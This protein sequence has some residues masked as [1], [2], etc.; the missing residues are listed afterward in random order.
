MIFYVKGDIIIGNP[1]KG[2][3][4]LYYYDVSYEGTKVFSNNLFRGSELIKLSDSIRSDSDVK[5]IE[6]A[7]R[8]KNH[9]RKCKIVKYVLI[10]EEKYISLTR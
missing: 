5:E 1:I 6:K 4:E 7:L 8:K 10:T 2:G 3:I 9:F